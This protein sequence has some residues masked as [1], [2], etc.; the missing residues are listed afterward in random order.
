LDLG[1]SEAFSPLGE[2]VEGEL[3]GVEDC[4]GDGGDIGVGAAEPGFDV[5][6]GSGGSAHGPVSSD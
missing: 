1:V 6:G 2:I 3:E 4:A 5:R